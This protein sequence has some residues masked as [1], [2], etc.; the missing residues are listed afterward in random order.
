MC[1]AGSAAHV[2]QHQGSCCD[3]SGP[4]QADDRVGKLNSFG[5][6]GVGHQRGQTNYCEYINC[7]DASRHTLLTS[8]SIA[9]V[10]SGLICDVVKI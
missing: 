9:R 1:S 10:S 5:R 4:E 2:G 6:L 3:L 7:S 8:Q